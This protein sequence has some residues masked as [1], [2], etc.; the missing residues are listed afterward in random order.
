MLKALENWSETGLPPITPR[1]RLE[2]LLVPIRI[3]SQPRTGTLVRTTR[4][5]VPGERQLTG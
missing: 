3:L 2:Q 1:K 5:E 4:F